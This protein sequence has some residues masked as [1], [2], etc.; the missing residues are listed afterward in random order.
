[1]RMQNLAY[2]RSRDGHFHCIGPSVGTQEGQVPV[3]GD[4]EVGLLVSI[5]DRI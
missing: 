3:Q 5:T 1:M 4:Q 2:R